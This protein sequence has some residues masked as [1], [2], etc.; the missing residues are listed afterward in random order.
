MTFARLDPEE[1][2]A[3]VTAD[4]Q[5]YLRVFR[6]RRDRDFVSEQDIPPPQ[7]RNGC[8]GYDLQAKDVD[9]DGVDELVV[10]F[11]GE[12]SALTRSVECAN[13]G[14]IQVFKLASPN[15]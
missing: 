2:P 7:W 3:L 15:R 12:G 9:A 5:G 8:Q 13:G 10:A 1:P 6:Q 14:A 11:A 4:S